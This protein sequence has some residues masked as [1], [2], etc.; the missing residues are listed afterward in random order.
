M[1]LL[2]PNSGKVSW[3]IRF[4]PGY[5]LINS[6]VLTDVDHGGQ[7]RGIGKCELTVCDRSAD[8]SM[9]KRHTISRNLRRQE[10]A[11]DELH[12]SNFGGNL[13]R[14]TRIKPSKEV[15]MP[16]ALQ[17]LRVIDFT[18]ALNGP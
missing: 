10:Y 9:R 16:G 1:F 18:H 11:G 7:P 3:L 13:I 5:I 2:M 8:K 12:H 15:T 14:H 6:A 17:D 4:L